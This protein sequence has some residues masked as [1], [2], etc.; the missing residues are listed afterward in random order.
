MPPTLFHKLFNK[1]NAFT[2]PSKCDKDESAFS[3]W[4][5][6]ELEPSQI[7]LIVYQDCERRGRH[8]LFDSD[9]KK[10][11]MEEASVMKTCSESQAKMFRKCCPLRPTG[12]SSSSLDSSSSCA[13]EPMDQSRFQG[14]SRCSSDPNMLGE[15]M[16]GSVA[17]SYKGSTLK[18]HQIRSPPQLML[19]KV[20]TART[21]SSVYG[22]LNTLQDSLEFINQDSRALRPDQNTVVSGFLGSIG[23]SQLC[24]PRRAFSE[25]GPLRLIKSA[26]FFSGHSN[27]MDM[28]AR[29]LYDERESGIARSASLSSLLITPF[30]SPGSSLTSSCASSYQRRWLRSQTTSLENGVFPRWSVE[31]SF[32]MSD[33]GGV[34]NLGVARKKKIA[35]GVIFLLSPNEDENSKFQEFFFSHFPLFE[36]HMNKLKSSIEQAMKMTRRSTDV[37]QRILA[38]NRMMDSL[39][40]FRMTVC[41]LYTMPRMPEPVWL[42]MMSGA[43]EKNQLCGHF[44]R[45]LSL[46]MEQAS[47]NQFVPALLTAVLTN[48]LAWVPTVMPNGQPPIKIFLEK[49]SSKSVHML[50]KTHPYNPL[51][52]QLGDLYGAIGSPVRLSRT[53]LVGRQKELVQRLLYVLTYFIRCSELLE[54][55][56]LETGNDEQDEEAFAVP[57][58][59]IT[60]SLRRG[61]V[62]ES[63]YVL[64][65]VHKPSPEG[66]E[67]G[68]KEEQ[69]TEHI[70]PVIAALEQSDSQ[71]CQ[72]VGSPLVSPL[73]E[74]VVKVG[75]ASLVT[76]SPLL[77]VQGQSDVCDSDVAP[78]SLPVKIVWS[79]G[80]PLEKKPP[81]KSTTLA[82]FLLDEEEEEPGTRVTFLIGESMSPESDTESQRHKVEDELKKH[83]MHFTEKPKQQCC[84]VKQQCSTVLP[85]PL[86]TDQIE[87]KDAKTLSYITS[88]LPCINAGAQEECMDLLDEY[89]SDGNSVET[90]TISDVSKAASQEVAEKQNL[91][92]TWM[93]SLVRKYEQDCQHREQAM[94]K[95]STQPINTGCC[96]K[97]CSVEQDKSIRVSLIVPGQEKER[98]QKKTSPLNEWEIPRNESSDSALGDSESEDAGQEITRQE[99]DTQSITIF[100]ETQTDWQEEIEVPFPRAKLAENYSKSSIA[101]F[102]RSL[103]GSYCPTYVPDFVLHGIPND[104][105]LRQSLMSDLAHAVQHPV[106][107]EPVAEAVCIIADTDRWTVQVASSQRPSTENKLGKDVLVS[108]LVSNLLHSTYQLYRLNLSPNF[109]I[110]HLE[111]RLQ[112]LYFK[113]KMLAEY[114]KGQ[115]RVHVKEL[116]MVL[117]IESSD[118]PLL[119]AIASTHSPYVAQI[120]L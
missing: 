117:G 98:E 23:F 119:A 62:E 96:V 64:V 33:E 67:T 2:P 63:E 86:I 11:G 90:R 51:W 48:H 50:A 14:A 70:M 52:A 42:S 83:K 3:S 34:S 4:P 60:T 75:T 102:G 85:K 26:S 45:E 66:I 37:N 39:N 19:S 35:I 91:Q 36:S 84:H 59:V 112:E 38:H 76:N 29:G 78:S 73:T 20:F 68:M 108:N 82:S 54:T 28:P 22:S 49:H 15:M 113:S 24:S 44:M 118:L 97:C 47:K 80:I 58:S 87:S 94:C 109:C 101:N 27:P 77:D 69:Q 5:S 61:E 13:S 89:F 10:R 9:T 18:I 92:E 93:E 95:C 88:S 43:L 1:R 30:S 65:T 21:G 115:T 104:N 8:I 111:D 100:S 99:Q 16:F 40:E 12:G 107:D 114:L 72:E 46:L 120:L 55:Y 56:A 6:P 110:M 71:I 53:V 32:N 74:T 81:D 79:S 103:F 116:G 105:K 57:G 41:N 31:E 7:R 17:M 106:L 25:Q